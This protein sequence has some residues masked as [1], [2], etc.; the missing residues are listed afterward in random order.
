MREPERAS[1]GVPGGG[2]LYWAPLGGRSVVVPP[3]PARVSG[4]ALLGDVLRD[5]VS[6][7]VPE[8]LCSARSGELRDS[9]KGVS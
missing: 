5:L 1:C 8:L 3:A 6:L 2:S 4:F 9:R 7:E